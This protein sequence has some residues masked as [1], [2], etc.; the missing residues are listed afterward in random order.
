MNGLMRLQGREV[1]MGPY[2]TLLDK[3]E[4]NE[5]SH[6]TRCDCYPKIHHLEK[7]AGHIYLI[8]LCEKECSCNI[9]INKVDFANKADFPGPVTHTINVMRLTFKYTLNSV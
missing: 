5:Q 9:F 1:A 8:C 6:V 4:A 3:G 7:Q 2:T